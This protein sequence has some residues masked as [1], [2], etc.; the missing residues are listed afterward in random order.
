M[1]PDTFVELGKS[2]NEGMAFAITRR[3][4]CEVY[5]SDPANFPKPEYDH[6]VFLDTAT[7][8]YIV[9]RPSADGSIDWGKTRFVNKLKR[10]R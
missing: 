6:A 1:Q 8:N 2:G 3:D 5:G 7:E 9:V 4:F 10:I